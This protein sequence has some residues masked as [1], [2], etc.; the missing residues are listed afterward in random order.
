MKWLRRA[1]AITKNLFRS[2]GADQD[3]D[4][5]I[6]SYAEILSDEKVMAGMKPDAA[7]RAAR[8]EMGGT[9]QV[10]E[11]VRSRRTGA[12][13][14]SLWQDVRYAVR[15]LYQKPG[16]TAVAIITLALGIGANSAIFSV[17]NA[18]LL[19]RI[20]IPSP[21]RV[22]MVWT[23]NPFHN[24]R[25]VPASVPDYFDWKT[26]GVFKS[27]AAFKDDGFNVRIGSKT[28]RIEGLRVT[29][30][31]FD[32]QGMNPYLGR[33]FNAEDMRPGN[34][35]V[36]V[37]CYH[38]WTSRFA[39]DPQIVGKPVVVNGQ[40]FIVVGVLPKNVLKIGQ[41]DLYTPLVFVPPL[42]TDRGSRSTLVVGRLRDGLSLAAA[43]QRMSDLSA[44][45]AKQY[46]VDAGSTVSLQ[47][48]KEAYVQDIEALVLLL[49][50]AVGFVLFVACANIA[51]LLLV[52]ATARQKEIAVRAALGATRS[53]LA[54]QLIAESVT[55]SIAGG[56]AG[57]LPAWG[58]IRLIA[59][60]KLEDL[61]RPDFLTLN[62][63]VVV[64]TLILSVIT[65]VLFGLAPVSQ[66]WKSNM[67]EPLKEAQRSHTASSQR[68]LNNIFVAG[69]IA[70]TMILLAGAG[71]ML[72]TFLHLRTA[73]PGY[74]TE[75]VLTMRTVLS[76]PQY[77]TPEKQAAFYDKALK[78]LE[79]LPAVKSAAATNLLPETDDVHGSAIYFAGRPDP[80]PGEVPLVLLGSVTADYFATMRIPILRGRS[81]TE[82][83]RA[84]T[85]PIAIIDEEAAK[86]YWRG[87]DPIGKL[88]K[89]DRKEP[90]RKV[91]GIAGDVEQ[92]LIVKLVKG[93]VPQVYLPFKQ[94]P[95]PDV[96]IVISSKTEPG[97][98]TS[99][100]R[101]SI[102]A[103][104]PDQPVFH[105]QTMRD[106]RATG[107]GPVRVATVLLGFFAA[108]ALLLAAVGIY[109][110]IS[111][112][113][114]QRTRE[115][116]IRMALGA[117]KAELFKLVLGQGGLLITAGA[118][119][120]LLGA[121]ALTRLMRSLLTD[122][123]PNDPFTFFGAALLL[124][125]VGLAASYI[126]AR[127]A[128]RVDPTVA[129]RCE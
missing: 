38:F 74:D 23:E 102:A 27:L 112:T 110:V 37:L 20:P 18:S 68:R 10:K 42:A 40:P 116:G 55:L 8:I 36:V 95:K 24:L 39:A 2:A 101:A 1:L 78:R 52:R 105:I 121:A 129:L 111:Y 107:R 120:G 59:G 126:P 125:A 86:K 11:E 17:M 73:N 122:I 50:C 64:F 75:R 97:S 108:I 90:F 94:A 22:V 88:I 44:R 35:R 119:I 127:R 115:I 106:A 67:N 45:M 70:I 32:I 47:P 56:L 80:K 13:L 114:G 14:E 12:R 58:G 128:S 91:V 104:D 77:D 85:P 109:G 103:L 46:S 93:R 82:Y 113:V 43:R 72:R 26:S 34:D 9:Q 79:N 99:S 3:L 15:M 19:A 28:E 16:F 76:G 63:S 33:V 123:S 61:P 84:N 92:N 62:G 7:R 87:E 83:D 51:N 49:L 100:A 29:S 30:E 53:R 6:R 117:N 81:F 25:E 57:I 60:F 96:A 48:A 118:I 4:D 71:L 41:E 31:W 54:C 69:E 89:L 98:L 124:I 5:E 21:D 65:G 66:L